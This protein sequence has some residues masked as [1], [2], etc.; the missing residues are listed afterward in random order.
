M[1]WLVLGGRGQLGAEFAGLIPVGDLLTWDRG[2]LD[3]TDATAV[4][5]IADIDVDVVVN[6]AAWTAVDAAEADPWGA[7]AVNHLG[8]RFVAE[9]VGRNAVN[10]ALIHLSTD[11]VFG[12]P[13]A[14]AERT[15]WPE[16]AQGDPRSAYGRSKW[17]GEQAVR[18]VLRR[19]AAIVRTAWLY[20]EHGPNFVRTMVARAHA[21]APVSVVR[22]QWGQPTWARDVAERVVALGERLV[23]GRAPFGTYH[24]TNAGE[25]T[26]WEFAGWIFGLTGA[27]P[28]LVAPMTSEALA[29]PAPRPTWSVLGQAAWSGAGF[30]PMRPWREALVEALPGIDPDRLAGRHR[31][32]DGDP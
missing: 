2:R 5:E 7:E 22:D 21:R 15:P 1:R 23:D 31:P 12:D 4:E 14:G 6:C 25:T 18:S 9:A 27:D 10:P 16:D 19:R 13:P 8:A 20:G 32:P 29:R 24:A 17:R 30:A 26:W 11:Y 28:G 3:V